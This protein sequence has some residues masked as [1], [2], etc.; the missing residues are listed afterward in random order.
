MSLATRAVDCAG[1]QRPTSSMLLDTPLPQLLADLDVELVET[2]ISEPTLTGYLA[3][4]RDGHRV[5]AMPL[6]RPSWERD[7]AA[8][9]ILAEAFDLPRP[10][11]P[12]ALEVSRS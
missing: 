5:L 12:A 1:R 8:R 9:V 10:A 3:I 11:L 4:R 2:R 7:I 6:G